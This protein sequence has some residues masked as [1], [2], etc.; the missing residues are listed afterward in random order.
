MVSNAL[1]TS[2]SDNWSTPQEIY[3]ALDKE[4]KFD[5][6]PCADKENHKTAEYFTIED[7]GLSRSWGGA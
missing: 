3:E 6:D 1:F 5:L 2:N 7:D 4:F